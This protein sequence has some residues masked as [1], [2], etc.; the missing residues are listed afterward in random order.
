MT[1][2]K[3]GEEKLEEIDEATLIEALIEKGPDDPETNLNLNKWTEAR[4]EEASTL[5]K[6]ENPE[7]VIDRSR[8]YLELRRA[9][10]YSMAK[11]NPLM[12]E[13]AEEAWNDAARLATAIGIPILIERVRRTAELYGYTVEN[14]EGQF[15]SINGDVIEDLTEFFFKRSPQSPA[16]FS[17]PK[18][19]T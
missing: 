9:E 14:F 13:Y 2:D 4:E 15:T 12:N 7:K 16:S 1:I 8:L 3:A 17:P 10:L 5:F 18:I 11:K 6:G 19:L